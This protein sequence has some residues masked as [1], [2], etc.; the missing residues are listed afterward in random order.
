MWTQPLYIN[1]TGLHNHSNLPQSGLNFDIVFSFCH[2]LSL[3]CCSRPICLCPSFRVKVEKS[4]FIYYPLTLSATNDIIKIRFPLS[5]H[6]VT[7]GC[8]FNC[9]S[10]SVHT[11]L[12]IIHKIIS[13]KYADVQFVKNGALVWDQSTVKAVIVSWLIIWRDRKLGSVHLYSRCQENVRH[14]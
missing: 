12:C 4:Y 14:T 3:L 6:V 9:H 7:A 13:M 11:I 5:V 2:I 1:I 8:S 10:V